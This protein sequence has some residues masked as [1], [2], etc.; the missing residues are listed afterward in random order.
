MATH[1]SILAWRIPVDRGAWWAAVH[2]VRKSDKTEQLSTAQHAEFIGQTLQLEKMF[3]KPDLFLKHC[4][5]LYGALC[6]F[7]DTQWRTGQEVRGKGMGDR[8]WGAG[9]LSED[10]PQEQGERG[11]QEPHG[12]L[13]IVSGWQGAT[14]HKAGAEDDHGSHRQWL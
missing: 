10:P 14:A 2:G 8:G 6:F 5:C 13:S 1:S 4:C 3:C 11:R 12:S 7:P 9:R